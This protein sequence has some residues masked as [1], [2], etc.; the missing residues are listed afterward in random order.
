MQNCRV[1]VQHRQKD[2]SHTE[3]QLEFVHIA[4]RGRACILCP[5][6]H[7]LRRRRRPGQPP[8]RRRPFPPHHTAHSR[9]STHTPQPGHTGSWLT[10]RCILRSHKLAPPNARTPLQE[11]RPILCSPARSQA[12]IIKALAGCPQQSP[13]RHSPKSF[14]NWARSFSCQL[15]MGA[16]RPAAAGAGPGKKW[17]Q[18]QS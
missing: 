18:L 4:Q 1:L 3:T 15:S 17:T 13:H 14:R 12:T 2:K 7:N 16:R 11:G 6:P 5:C 10:R 8:G 9:G